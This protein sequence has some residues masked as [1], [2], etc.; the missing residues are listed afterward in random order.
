MLT[1]PEYPDQLNL[2]GLIEDQPIPASFRQVPGWDQQLSAYAPDTSVYAL[3][4]VSTRSI[5]MP[6]PHTM[7]YA[8]ETMAYA[9]TTTS[10]Y[11]SDTIAQRIYYY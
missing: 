6:T 4:T 2:E 8:P 3:H 5:P 11:A 7:A 10:A 1:F 9:S